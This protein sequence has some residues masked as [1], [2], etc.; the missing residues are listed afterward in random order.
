MID[1]WETRELDASKKDDAVTEADEP[2]YA[3]QPSA[4]SNANWV[5]ILD[6]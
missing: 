3:I 6:E 5:S 2:I 1:G 4:C